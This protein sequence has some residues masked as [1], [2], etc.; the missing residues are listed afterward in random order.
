MGYTFRPEE[1]RGGDA[2]EGKFCDGRTD[3]FRDSAQGRGKYGLVVP[4]VWNFTQDRI[5]DPGP[6]RAVRGGGVERSHPSAA[7]VCQPTA[8]P[9]R[10]HHRGRQTRKAL[11]GSTQDPRTPAATA[12]FRS[13]G[14]SA[15]HHSRGLRSTRSGR[16]GEPVQDTCRG[17]TAFCWLEPE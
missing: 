1:G 6:L 15:Q 2:M 5:Q 16:P 13:E 14:T 11:L 9:N 4:R 17:N 7:S 8:R 10:S 3:A 12:T